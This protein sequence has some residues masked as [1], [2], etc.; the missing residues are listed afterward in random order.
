MVARIAGRSGVPPVA[1][2]AVMS[3]WLRLQDRP[4]SQPALFERKAQDFLGLAQRLTLP[5]QEGAIAALRRQ[6][7]A[8][9][10]AG[11]FAEVDKALA[12][13][14]LQAIGDASD[15]SALSREQRLAIGET[16]ADR[17]ALS[18][19][20]TAPEGYREAAARY[21]EAAA[22]LAAADI[23]RSQS[24]TLAQAKALSR[25]S[26]DFG[27]REGFEAALPLLRGLV[28]KLDRLADSVRFAEVQDALAAALE[29]LGALTGEIRFREQALAY[30]RAG[31]EYLDRDEAPALWR[32]LKIRYGR[33]AVTLGVSQHDDNLLEEAIANFASLLAS[34]P[35]SDDEA[36]WLEAE[37]MI[38]RARATLGKRRTDLALLERAFNGLSRVCSAVDRQREPL[39]W[40]QIQDQ[41]G[42]VL[43]SMAERYS[44]PVVLEEAI[45]V[46]D[47]ALEELRRDAVP[48]LWART[49][50]NQAEAMLELARRSKSLDLVQRGLAQMVEA[51]DIARE[52]DPRVM[53]EY[54]V[55]LSEAGAMAQRLMKD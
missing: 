35:R 46:F 32:L 11:H 31:L 5:L 54:Q 19:L 23:E 16:R 18:F 49:R 44:E 20:K 43:T 30:S 45:K 36:R 2:A 21:G 38:S 22:L 3:D 6:A 10:N 41:M 7:A 52:A 55:R 50:M 12:Q 48:A 51:V 4:T 40:A 14:E 26:E 39:R 25:S 33:L 37:H 27:G 13:A 47:A 15:L 34:W 1:L 42:S 29:G 53:G 9:L 28:S 17:A 8:A 24:A